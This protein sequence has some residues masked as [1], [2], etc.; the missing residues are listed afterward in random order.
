MAHDLWKRDGGATLR[1]LTQFHEWSGEGSSIGRIDHIEETESR[2]RHANS[3][4]IYQRN[5]RLGM[6][7]ESGNESSK[8]ATI[9]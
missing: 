6:I 5:Q 1:T 4:A 8:D 3:W 7:D 9:Q 2:H